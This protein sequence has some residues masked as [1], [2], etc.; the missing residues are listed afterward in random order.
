MKV[1]YHVDGHQVAVDGEPGDTLMQL[2]VK[3]QISRIEGECGGEL[4]CAT[5]HLYVDG[6]QGFRPASQEEDELLELADDR[7]DESRLSCQ[8]VLREGMTEIEV[9]VP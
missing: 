4:S 3:Q 9:T 7:T 6:S 1:I 5:C 2:A 8:L